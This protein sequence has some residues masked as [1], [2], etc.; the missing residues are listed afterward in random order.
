ML[1]TFLELKLRDLRSLGCTVLTGC[2][3]STHSKKI[4]GSR[5]RD[6]SRT[7]D[8][9]TRWDWM[10]CTL[11]RFCTPCDYFLKSCF[12][13]EVNKDHPEV[14]EELKD[15]ICQKAAKIPP[16][17]NLLVVESFTIHLH[18]CLTMRGHHLAD[19]LYKMKWI[20]TVARCVYFWDEALL[21][22]FFTLCRFILAAILAAFRPLYSPVFFRCFL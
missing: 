22:V 18:L 2:S 5:K 6:V 4:N 1:W 9:F 17:M 19:V 15:A 8:F 14:T 10:I 3:Y 7:F 12:K 11:P 13:V 20:K 16:D 21:L